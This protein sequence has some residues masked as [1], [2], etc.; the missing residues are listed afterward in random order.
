MKWNNVCLNVWIGGIRIGDDFY[1]CRITDTGG[2]IVLLI[3]K[4]D[5]I[6]LRET[7]NTSSVDDVKTFA[8]D[9]VLNHHK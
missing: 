1:N 7:Y 5:A 2:G 6:L 4:D 3:Q 8:E 9:F